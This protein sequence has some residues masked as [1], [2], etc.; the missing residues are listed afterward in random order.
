MVGDVKVVMD[1]VDRDRP[2]RRPNPPWIWVVAGLVVGFGFG[3][4]LSTPVTT[5]PVPADDQTPQEPVSTVEEIPDP[6]GIAD[7]VPGFPDALVAV[8]ETEG[9]ALEYL[10]W[11][12]AGDP[13][14]RPLPAGDF[15]TAAFDTSGSWLAISTQVPD[16]EGLV[17]SVGRPAFLQPHASNVTSFKWHDGNQPALAYTQVVDDEWHLWEV[18]PDRN[19]EIKARGLDPAGKVAAWGDWGWAIQN[20]V[21]NQITLLTPDGELKTTVDGVVF[22][23]YPAGWMVFGD[24]EGL[25]WLSS[26]G[27]LRSLDIAVES[28]GPILTLAVSPDGESVAML[29]A[30]GLKVSPLNGDGLVMVAPF[31][32]ELPV[33]VWSS[34]SRFVVLPWMRGVVVF[35]VVGGGRSFEQLTNYMVNTVSVIRVGS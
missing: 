34:D 14:A 13:I 32:V 12:V 4:L 31:T 6:V 9:R 19:S 10:L 1:G 29:G 11:P 22:D 24:D 20:P 28:I 18:G 16:S 5:A 27:G 35:D 25:H 26:G 3:A 30:G 17:L 15:G 2:K 8:S 33:L 21:N 7:A 23:S